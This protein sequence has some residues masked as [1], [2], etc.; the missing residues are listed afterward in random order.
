MIKKILVIDDSALM[1]RVLSDIIKSDNRFT[2]GDVASNGLEG[3][4][5]I[6]RDGADYDA[7]ILDIN[8]PKMNGIEF[9]RMLEKH[10]I[11]TK[12]IVV[13]TV[14]KE[15]A[16][17]TIEA[18]ELGA[19]DFV[20]KP[21]S[22]YEVKSNQFKKKILRCL[23]A[24]V[25][26]EENSSVGDS[27]TVRTKSP[28]GIETVLPK[29]RVEA[30]KP[31]TRTR[32]R[33]ESKVSNKLI[34]LACSTGG[35]KALQSVVPL[36]PKNMDCSLLI[37][38]HMPAGFTKSLAQR[39]NEMSQIT[40]KEAEDGEILK[41]GTAYIAMGGKHMQIRKGP[42][43]CNHIALTDEPARVGLKPCA[44]MMYESLVTSDYDEITCVVLTGMGSDGTHG[45]K[46]LKEKKEVY[47]IAQDEE[48][49]TVYG[50]PKSVAVAGLVDEVHPLSKIAEAMIN[51]V[52]VK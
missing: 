2:V 7:V 11:H 51:N 15:G 16:K 50:M 31:V 25:K 22:F 40:V 48:T 1:R 27:E 8:M 21:E 6:T 47:V 35:P 36:L 49:S 33:N 14:A 39:L 43:G 42:D 20:T 38:Q 3:F 44:D 34:A 12:V 52:G 23:C 37:V 45:I 19:F 5:L 24:A 41:K 46:L 13:S 10:H 29:Q 30:V 32:V 28:S 9:L 18:L 17:E 4:D 26:I